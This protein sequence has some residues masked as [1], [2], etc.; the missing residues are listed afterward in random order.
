VLATIAL[1][2]IVASLAPL[3]HAVLVSPAETLR[4]E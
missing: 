2:T 3:R 1:T 4:A